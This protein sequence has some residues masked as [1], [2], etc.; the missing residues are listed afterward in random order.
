[1][2][3]F[4]RLPSGRCICGSSPG[5]GV[6]LGAFTIQF[7]G[8][9]FLSAVHAPALRHDPEHHRRTVDHHAGPPW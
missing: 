7:V 9:S 6:M 3:S 5:S 4:P 2:K 1:M 8:G